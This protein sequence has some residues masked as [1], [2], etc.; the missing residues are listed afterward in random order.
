MRKKQTDVVPSTLMICQSVQQTE[1]KRLMRVLLDS[2]GSHSLIHARMLPKGT[3]PVVLPGPRNV[4]TIMGQFEAN[5]KVYLRDIVLP[6][7]DKTKRIDGLEAYV[8]DAPCRYD[9][10]LGRD[11][12]NLTGMKLD[13]YSGLIQWLDQEVLMKEEMQLR[14]PDKWHAFLDSN[15]ETAEYDGYIMDAKYEATSAKN[16]AE[17]QKHLSKTQQ[18]RLENILHTLTFFFFHFYSFRMCNRQLRLTFARYSP[19]WIYVENVPD[20]THIRKKTA[21]FGCYRRVKSH[22]NIRTSVDVL[23][24]PRSDHIQKNVTVGQ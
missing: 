17:Q 4:N 10:I 8:F 13:F 1:S 20:I 12:L 23:Q 7:F 18:L 2:G 19:T 6:E 11:F 21:L 5:R 22:A 14:H 3:N 9:M 16:I 15:D 24:Y